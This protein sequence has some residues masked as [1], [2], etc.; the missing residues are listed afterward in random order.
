M[1]LDL[2]INLLHTHIRS[3]ASCC[4]LNRVK[5]FSGRFY[6]KRFHFKL[7]NNLL[8]CITSNRCD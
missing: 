2:W 1:L 7:L 6:C 4:A 8:I 3:K 5:D